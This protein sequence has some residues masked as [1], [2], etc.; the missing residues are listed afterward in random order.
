[1]KLVDDRM[2]VTEA[3]VDDVALGLGAI[4]HAINLENSREALA[5]ALDHVGDEFAEQ[6]V[7]C[8]LLV[9]IA[10]AL[11]D[12]LGILD[13]HGKARMDFNLEFALGALD[14]E[15]VA[16]ELGL[17]ALVELYRQ[18]TYTRHLPFLVTIP[19]T[20]SRRRRACGAPLAAASPDFVGAGI[21]PDAGFAHP[22]DAADDGFARSG[23]AKLEDELALGG[24]AADLD[25]VEESF[26]REHA[27]DRLA[28]A[29]MVNDEFVEPR[30]HRVADSGQQL[31][32]RIGLRHLGF[33][34]PTGFDDARQVTA[35]SQ[36]AQAQ[37]AHLETSKKG[38]S[39]PAQG[40]SVVPPHLELGR[41][42]RLHSEALLRHRLRLSGHRRP[43]LAF[44][45]SAE[46]HPKRP[47]QHQ[48]LEV[49]AG[50]GG[51]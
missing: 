35:M 48:S 12:Q 36:L 1:R 20:G 14:L 11:H 6:S 42:R 10:R 44:R 13:L 34:L 28:D 26:G 32:D 17:D 15:R 8:A 27:A 9:G 19:G 25:A 3:Q 33:S 39:P 43:L 38:A 18:S 37:P 24:F 49:A 40:A 51:D 5:H 22:L 31:C 46:R 4:T 21:A 29:G 7:A 30:A 16:L 45:L 47:K 41:A 50:A 2:R 23:I